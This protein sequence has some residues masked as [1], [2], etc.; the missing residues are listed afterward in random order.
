[1]NKFLFAVLIAG[2]S[3]CCANSL[4]AETQSDLQYQQAINAQSQY[5]ALRSQGNQLLREGKYPEALIYHEKAFEM[6]R[7]TSMEGVSRSKLMVLYEKVD[8]Y[9]KALEQC[10]WFLT[11]SKG[12]T[13]LWN[14]WIE[15]KQRLL[16]KIEAQ[17]GESKMRKVA[18]LPTTTLSRSTN[19]I[20][21]F[22][23]A[24][25]ASQKKFLEKNLPE[26]TEIL[27]LSKQ[28]MLAEH[29][30][31]FAD[32]KMYYE[33]LLSREEDV[34]AAQ[35]EVAWPMLHCA[36]QRMSE[37]TGDEAREK[38]MLLWIKPNMLDPQ[39]QFHQ[40]LVNLMPDVIDHLNKQIK[41]YQL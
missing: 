24:D 2:F 3:L 1:M 8:A 10:Q 39:G 30:G 9:S 28:A 33:Q 26:E 22:Q 16:R 38:E 21:D 17:K 25:Y 32:A 35:G 40:Y 5:H 12:N 19:I 20:S 29:A 34:T 18:A 41:K 4:T 23:G 14:D 37:L 15:T 31:K 13:P 11:H 7:G 6:A 27:R 36:V